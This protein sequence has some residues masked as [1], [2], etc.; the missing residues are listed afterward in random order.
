MQPSRDHRGSPNTDTPRAI[1]RPD[2]ATRLPLAHVPAY[3]EPF[4]VEVH[5]HRDTVRVAPTGEL[6]LA[7]VPA[8]RGQ[9][10]ELTESGFRSIVLDLR[11]VESSTRPPCTWSSTLAGMPGRTTCSSR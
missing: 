11:G 8:L 7:T 3:G 9:L 4:S 1:G 2:A 5:P 6:D 10:L